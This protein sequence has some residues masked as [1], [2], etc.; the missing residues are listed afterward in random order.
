MG[1]GTQPIPR[2]AIV[3]LDTPDGVLDTRKGDVSGTMAVLRFEPDPDVAG[4]IRIEY[5]MSM[6]FV[7]PTAGKSTSVR[8][9]G[10]LSLEE[11]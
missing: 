5:V 2:D 9:G 1:V 3:I 6:V 10:T 7:D 8:S 11:R 4:R